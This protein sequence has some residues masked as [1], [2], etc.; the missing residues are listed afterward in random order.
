[1]ELLLQL[2]DVIETLVVVCG[3]KFEIEICDEV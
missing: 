3:V 2:D 1:V